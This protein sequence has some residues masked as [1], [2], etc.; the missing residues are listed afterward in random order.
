MSAGITKGWGVAIH[1]GA[2]SIPVE[3]PP[4]H[5]DACMAALAGVLDLGVQ[6]LSAGTAAID[7]AEQLVT[8][9]EDESLFNAGRGS[10]F[11][12]GGEH[13]LEAAI[14]D[15]STLECGAVA[16]LRTVRNPIRLAR[17][18]MDQTRHVLLA[19]T[20]AEEYA[21][22]LGMERVDPSWFDTDRRLAELEHYRAEPASMEQEGSTVGAV[23]RDAEGRLAAA[24]ST[25]GMTGKMVGRIGDS[26]LIGCGTYAD[27]GCAVS[28]TGKGE[29][30]IRQVAAHKVALLA[31]SEGLG[32]C[33]AVERVLHMMPDAAGGIIAIDQGGAPVALFSSRGMYRGRADSTGLFE[34]LIHGEE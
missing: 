30:F 27:E 14:M 28:C 16:G 17:C 1:G 25:G 32:A 4:G 13:E 22:S 11:T 31:G 9:L 15:G 20:G 34:T 7:V 3:M 21:E 19:G 33:G 23:V 6:L 12:A 2:G 10:V 26:P 24:T 29:E 5:R 8:G 18:I